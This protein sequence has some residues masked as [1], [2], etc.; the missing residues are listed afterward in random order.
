MELWGKKPNTYSI[1][2][3]TPTG[4]YIPHIAESLRTNQE[5]RFVFE[6]TTISVNYNLVETHTNVQLILLRIRN[7]TPGIWSFKVYSRG[8]LNGSFHIW[9]PSDDFISENTYF[10]NP[11][12]YTTITSPGN[13]VLSITATAYNPENNSLYDKASRGFS[14][15]G[16]I[17]PVLAAPGVNVVVPTLAKGFTNASGTSLAAAY[18]AGFS[19]IMLEW[20]IVKGYYPK[21]NTTVIKK[22]LIRGANRSK[23]LQYPNRDWGYGIID[24]YNVFNVLRTDFPRI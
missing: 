14:A 20:G 24:L 18:T 10:T 1:D 3:L 7:P 6:A 19:A 21:M 5:I 22:Y 11:D 9:L 15:T 2:I 16:V 23:L 8:D 13:A 17:V 4:E 12:R